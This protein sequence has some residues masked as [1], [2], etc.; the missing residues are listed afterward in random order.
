MDIKELKKKI[1]DNTLDD[2]ILILKYQDNKYLAYH[3]INAICKNKN[4]EK[5]FIDSLKDINDKDDLFE[6]ESKYIYIL[7]VEKLEEDVNDTLKDVIIVC[8]DVPSNL[9]VDYIDM[10]KLISWQIEDFVK[11]RLPG[12]DEKEIKWL[13]EITHYDIYRLDNECIKLEL[14]NSAA[15]KIL[16][17]EINEE[18]GYSDLNSLTIFNFTNALM[19]KDLNSIKNIL[20]DLENIDIEATG[21]VTIMIKQIKN[22]IDIQINPKNTASS[23]GMSPKQFNAIKYNVGKFKNEQLINMFEF[24]TEVDYRLKNGELALDETNEG[25]VRNNKLVDYITVNLLNLSV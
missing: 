2:S 9:S 8:K 13:C 5:L 12:L 4:K 3:Y 17:R 7:D 18:N 20:S 16:F 19:K 6:T 22:L 14:F 24:L 21:L 10:T 15:Q 11:V 23:L 1:L 25:I